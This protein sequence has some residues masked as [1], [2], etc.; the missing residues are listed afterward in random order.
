MKHAADPK[1]GTMAEQAW[2]GGILVL[3]GIGFWG[4]TFMQWLTERSIR[5][6]GPCEEEDDAE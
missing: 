4:L 5:R 2:A 1:V 3:L 6:Y